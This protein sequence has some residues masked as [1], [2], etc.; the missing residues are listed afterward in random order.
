MK[1]ILLLIFIIA[2]CSLS[3]AAQDENEIETVQNLYMKYNSALL[4][5]D[6]RAA[7]DSLS[8][9]IKKEV[10]YDNFVKA[11]TEIAKVITLKASQL[12]DVKLK[13]AIAGGKSITYLDFLPMP[14]Q[15][16]LLSGKIESC[17]YF[18]RENGKWKIAAADDEAT[19]EFVKKYPAATELIKPEKTRLYYK[20]GGYWIAFE[21]KK[22]KKNDKRIPLK[23]W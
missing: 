16:E 1:R 17:V 21:Y 6:W 2:F 9:D 23:S 11:N 12:N 15:E 8:T 19:E 5:G 4:A 22:D 7:Y 10:N 3:A 20:K 13:G 18:L 14:D